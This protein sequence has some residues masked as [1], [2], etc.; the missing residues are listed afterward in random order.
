LSPF[1]NDEVFGIFRQDRAR[2]LKP[3]SHWPA[4]AI[5]ADAVAGGKPAAM[6]K[7]AEPPAGSVSGM[8]TMIW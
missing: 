1:E 2:R 8:A 7:F 3:K 6:L 4:S 5:G